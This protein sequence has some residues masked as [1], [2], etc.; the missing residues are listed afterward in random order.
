M[1]N[2]GSK[3]K[4][5]RGLLQRNA[6][7]L[8]SFTHFFFRLYCLHLPRLI[9]GWSSPWSLLVGRVLTLGTDAEALARGAL[10]EFNRNCCGPAAMEGSLSAQV[11]AATRQA[12]AQGSQARLCPSSSS[13]AKGFWGREGTLGR[14]VLLG[15]G[16]K[17][18]LAHV[19]LVAPTVLGQYL[20]ALIT[21]TL[22]IPFLFAQT[23]FYQ[24]AGLYLH[25][26]FVPKPDNV[27]KV[28]SGVFR[29]SCSLWG[30][31]C[32]TLEFHVCMETS[33]ALEE[34]QTILKAA[35]RGGCVEN[36]LFPQN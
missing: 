17:G 1:V 9:R 3:L 19:S 6:T 18:L 31:M 20:H 30:G 24:L 15:R 21:N 27:S 36:F 16:W 10:C 8:L 26:R 14:K 33:N 34:K 29:G 22:F 13:L 5:L 12:S 2:L 32:P 35:R 7:A 28:I 11:C 4:K 23:G 25:G